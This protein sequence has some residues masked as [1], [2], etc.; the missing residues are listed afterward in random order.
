M[1]NTQGFI[2]K[3][4]CETNEPQAANTD[5]TSRNKAVFLKKFIISELFAN[6][7]RPLHAVDQRLFYY[8]TNPFPKSPAHSLKF[9]KVPTPPFLF[10]Q[11]SAIIAESCRNQKPGFT[12]IQE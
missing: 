3:T 8:K 6:F 9:K 5:K 12:P 4:Y 10:R 1:H 7:R 11:Q 2:P